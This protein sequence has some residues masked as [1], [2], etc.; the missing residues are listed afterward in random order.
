MDIFGGN[1]H[2]ALSSRSSDI[3]NWDNIT[4][5]DYFSTLEI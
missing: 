4:I 3:T 1:R 2:F 5:K